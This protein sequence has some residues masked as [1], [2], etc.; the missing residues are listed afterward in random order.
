MNACPGRSSAGRA[1]PLLLPGVPLSL[2]QVAV[3]R[4]TTRTPAA[5]PCSRVVRLTPSG[6]SHDGRVVIVV[7]PQRVESIAAAVRGRARAASLAV[8]SRPRDRCVARTGRVARPF[9][10]PPTA[11]GLETRR[12]CPASRPAA[13]HRSE[14]VDP[15]PGVLDEKLPRRRR[16]L[17]VER[18][19]PVVGVAIGE[20]VGREVG[21]IVAVGTEVVVDDVE[22]DGQS[23]SVRPIDEAAQIV[24]RSIQ[25]RRRV[26]VDAVV[27]PTD[28][29]RRSPPPASSR[30]R[31][32]PRST[33]DARQFAH[34]R[35][36]R[37]F[38]VNVP[39]C[40]S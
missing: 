16:P 35:G 10:P 31:V 37:A 7:V 11:S 1:A 24:G 20:V 26:K 30:S 40:I 19:A 34:R 38:R 36:P 12:G 27:S 14:L 2:I 25:P 3:L 15:V 29:R 9:A 18:L 21:E 23:E 32:T 17:E 5:I 13:G 28:A 22:N 8:R 33:P 6:Q 39:T 4:G